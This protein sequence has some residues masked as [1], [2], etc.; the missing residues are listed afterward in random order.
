MKSRPVW[1]AVTVLLIAVLA[2]NSA[3]SLPRTEVPA[4]EEPSP[5]PEGGGVDQGFFDLNLSRSDEEGL[6]ERA[7]EIYQALIGAGGDVD[8][9]ALIEA[10]QQL[11]DYEPVG[12]QWKSVGPA[13][14]KGVFLPQGQVPGSGR[15]NGFVIDPRD[16]N[17]VYAAAS[18]GG[19][20]KTTD[21]GRTWKCLTDAQVPLI[22]GRLVMNPQ[23]PDTLYAL[24]G[25]FDGQVSSTGTL[26]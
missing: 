3:E 23:D 15:V 1:A 7:N 22:Y 20:W 17:V 11:A 8:R 25:E 21:G 4:T 14:I 5:T 6:E 2:C 16:S 26:V 10:Y 18:V 13:P 24:L 19:I 9:G 12:G